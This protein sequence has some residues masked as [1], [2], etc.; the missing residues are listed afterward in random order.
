MSNFVETQAD[1]VGT[2]FFSSPPPGSGN[3]F[4]LTP[5]EDKTWADLDVEAGVS[6]LIYNINAESELPFDVEVADIDLD[7]KFEIIATNHQPSTCFLPP[8]IPFAPVPGRVYAF[9]QEAPFDLTSWHSEI[10]IDD[11]Y[12]QPDLGPLPP[13]AFGRLAPGSPKPFTLKQDCEAC[14]PWI[15]VSG[16]EAGLVWLLE[17]I[18]DEGYTDHVIFDINHVYGE[19]T[20][21]TEDE[22]GETISTIGSVGVGYSRRGFAEL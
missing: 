4:I 7:G 6:A 18:G 2:S 19:C 3:I 9:K 22:N 10:L 20:T 21:Q 11:I 16:D 15:I 5:P 1:I 17:P 13:G 8:G 14:R 12:P